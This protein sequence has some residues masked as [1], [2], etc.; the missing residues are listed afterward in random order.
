MGQEKQFNIDVD[1]DLWASAKIEA[2]RQKID[3]KEFVA[4]AIRNELEKAKEKET[5]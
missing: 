5:V 1:E 2:I 3:L 4:Q